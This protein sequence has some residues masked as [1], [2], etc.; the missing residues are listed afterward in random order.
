MEYAVPSN[1]SE[2]SAWA[3]SDATADDTTH[4]AAL[5]LRP[6]LPR[7]SEVRELAFAFVV[8]TSRSMYGESLERAAHSAA[9]P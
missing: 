5:A 6:K 9:D 2:L 7:S 8:D 3:Y 1:E 4:Y